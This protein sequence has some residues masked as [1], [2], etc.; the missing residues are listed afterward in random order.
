M[1]DTRH[2]GGGFVQKV[3]LLSSSL[4]KSAPAMPHIGHKD[5]S[6]E[7]LSVVAHGYR[8]HAYGALL[9]REWD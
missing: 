1:L 2:N 5:V 8:R 3:G 9:E 4:S 6:L 7:C